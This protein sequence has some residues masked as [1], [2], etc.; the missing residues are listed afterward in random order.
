MWVHPTYK[1]LGWLSLLNWK[2]PR[3]RFFFFSVLLPIVV[4]ISNYSLL[5]FLFLY[6]LYTAIEPFLFFQSI[7]TLHNTWKAAAA[8]VSLSI[9]LHATLT[10]DTNSTAAFP[11]LEK[12]R[13]EENKKE[14]DGIALTKTNWKSFRGSCVYHPVRGSCRGSWTTTHKKGRRNI[15]KNSTLKLGNRRMVVHDKRP[16]E[17]GTMPLVLDTQERNVIIY[18]HVSVEVGPSLRILNNALKKSTLV[19]C[20]IISQLCVFFVVVVVKGLSV[21]AGIWN[22]GQNMEDAG[23][24]GKNIMVLHL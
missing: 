23:K 11:P 17:R 22:W 20:M 13:K 18:L 10:K 14:E 1:S 19:V 3:I 24:R 6:R 7:N 2:R 4:V 9:P 12:K 8:S 5:L 21:V 16:Q 15:G